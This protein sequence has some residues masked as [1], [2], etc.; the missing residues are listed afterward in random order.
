MALGQGPAK[1]KMKNL[2]I[3][4]AIL[5]L[6]QLPT[7]SET[8]HPQQFLQSISGAKNEGEQ[9]Y[10]HFCSNCHAIKPLISL[11]APRIG[12]A[13]WSIRLKQGMK[14]LFK[15]TDEGLNAMPAR[16]GCFECTDEQLLKAIQYMI[17]KP[18]SK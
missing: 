13:D 9:I 14:V 11:G 15:H 6:V 1:E 2:F 10:Q 5:L 7:Y 4:N 16:G 12:K 18:A 17:P 8:H 3:I